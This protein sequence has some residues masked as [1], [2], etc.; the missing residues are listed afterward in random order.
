MSIRRRVQAASRS[1]RIGWAWGLAL[2]VALGVGLGA[3]AYHGNFDNPIQRRFQWR[4][5]IGGDDIRAACR[6]G[7]PGNIDRYRFVYNGRFSE[8]LRTY[9]VVGDGAGGAYLT[10]RATGP[11]ANFSL[12]STNDLLAPLRWREA[13]VH[14][15]PAEFEAIRQ[16]MVADGFLQPPRT[17]GRR[18]PSDRFYWLVTGCWEGQF[19][20]GAWIF[21]SDDFQALSFPKLLLYHDQTGLAVNRPRAVGGGDP[22]MGSPSRRQDAGMN[23]PFNVTIRANGIGG[24]NLF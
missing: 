18:F 15:K 13:R 8:Q 4:S 5:F 21:P 22:H 9:E 12:V 3:C 11:F 6:P 10:A 16:A 14:L 24:G 23:T 19:H 17:V 2:A 1:P 20:F 7:S